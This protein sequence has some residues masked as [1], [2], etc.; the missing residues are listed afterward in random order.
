[1]IVLRSPTA[2]LGDAGITGNFGCGSSCALS[3]ESKSFGGTEDDSSESRATSCVR[4]FFE[5]FFQ[6]RRCNFLTRF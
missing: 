6:I 1:M 4:S 3:W 2:F 5:S